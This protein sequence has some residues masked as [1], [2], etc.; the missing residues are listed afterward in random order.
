MII[1]KTDSL[2][3][4]MNAQ[5]RNLPVGT[6]LPSLREL[7]KE[8][9][10]S[11]TTLNRVITQLRQEKKIR[12][13]HG[14][15]MFVADRPGDDT[16][17]DALDIVYFGSDDALNAPGYVKELLHGMVVAC[18]QDQ[19][20]TTVS[21]LPLTASLDSAINRFE[22]LECKAVVTLFLRD[23]SFINYFEK[24]R[25]PHLAISPE[26][27]EDLDNAVYIDNEALIQRV[28]HHLLMRGHRKIAYLKSHVKSIFSRDLHLREFHYYRE[29]IRHG[30]PVTLDW[31]C[32]AGHTYE[33]IRHAVGELV[34]HH[35]GFTALIVDDQA[36]GAVYDELRACGITPGEAVS[37]VGI[38]DLEM[39]RS[40]QPQ[41]SSLRIS[42]YEIARQA[43][44]MLNLIYAAYD[45][46]Q[47]HCMIQPELIMRDSVKDLSNN[48]L[49]SQKGGC[50]TSSMD[51]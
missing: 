46:K 43:Y 32:S 44:R 49:P 15:G 30:L 39:N 2:L 11:Q 9:H 34:R 41:L 4:Q 16:R 29:C 25:I 10:V 5:L 37:V 21:T 1:S 13:I 14:N 33:E 31:F 50:H 40:L 48:S 8:Y 35:P 42:Q 45:Q 18:G 51:K 38:D 47:P 17:L 6:K 12:V 28:M 20:S 23:Y 7:Q 19:V 24:L 36:A 3:W 27:M 26:M 22:K